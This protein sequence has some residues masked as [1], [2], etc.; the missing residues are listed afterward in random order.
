MIEVISL[1]QG[2]VNADKRWIFPKKVEHKK[3]Y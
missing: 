1:S 2:T 3:I